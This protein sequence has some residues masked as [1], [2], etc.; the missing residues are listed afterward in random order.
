MARFHVSVQAWSLPIRLCLKERFQTCEHAIQKNNI[1]FEN[2]CKYCSRPILLYSYASYS[3]W[4]VCKVTNFPKGNIMPSYKSCI[5]FISVFQCTWLSYLPWWK[6]HGAIC[7]DAISLMDALIL[8][9]QCALTVHVL[10]GA[11]FDFVCIAS[12]FI[13]FLYLY[14]WLIFKDDFKYTWLLFISCL[15]TR[16]LYVHGDWSLWIPYLWARSIQYSNKPCKKSF[17]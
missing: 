1:W 8:C 14:T 15:S 12:I 17:V 7:I 10:K 2:F 9:V 13:W 16:V 4:K 3:V 11:L 5:P 6:V